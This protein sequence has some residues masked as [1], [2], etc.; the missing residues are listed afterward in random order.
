VDVA[1]RFLVWG[2]S[3]CG[4]IDYILMRDIFGDAECSGFFYVR[5]RLSAWIIIL[6]GASIMLYA[7]VRMA[8]SRDRT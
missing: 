4:P 3:C 8:V 7:L 2:E 6:I 1:L 5:G